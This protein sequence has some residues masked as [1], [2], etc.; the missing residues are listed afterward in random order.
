MEASMDL[1][2]KT[3]SD[4]D[5]WIANHESKGGTAQPL[6]RQL[7]EERARRTQLTQKLDLEISLERLK[8]AARRGVCIAYG[9]L[10]SASG[11]EW[12]QARYQMNGA[13]GHLD[14]LLD[15]CH[16]R[17]LPLLTAICVNQAGVARGELGKDALEGFAKGAQR[18]GF[19]VTDER[20]FHHRCRDD[21][22]KWGREQAGKAP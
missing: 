18:L 10:A 12:S 15:L 4:I 8:D 14:R 17:G 5:Q 6:Y 9:D 3:D 20:T 2:A 13:S 21:C 7:L 11:I 1:K 19:S 16:A 22:W